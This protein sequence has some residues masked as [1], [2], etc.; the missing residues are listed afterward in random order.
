[1]SSALMTLS[2]LSEHP[3]VQ[4]PMAGGASCPE[5]VAAVSEAGGFGFLAAGYKT[6]EAMYE[7]MKQLRRLTGRPFGVMREHGPYAPP[8]YPQVHHLTAG[9]RKAAAR[10]GDPQGMALWAGQGH[11]LART[12][13]AG[14][15]VELLAAELYAALDT[16][17]EG[18]ARRGVA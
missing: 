9:V 2:A 14:Q 12:L 16:A 7:E 11:R 10:V 8:A 3:I 6:P 17:R 13:P 18:L 4:A 1:M 5:L 15:L